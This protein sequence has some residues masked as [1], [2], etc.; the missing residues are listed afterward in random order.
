MTE[1]TAAYWALTFSKMTGWVVEL[2]LIWIMINKFQ[3]IGGWKPF[4]VML[5]YAL[6]LS[7]YSIA[8]FFLFHPFTKLSERI[9]KGELDDILTKPVNPFLYLC[10]R[11]FSAGY[12]SNLFT[13]LVALVI[14]F[15]QLGIDMNP[16][17]ILFL[18][19][20][21]LGGALIQGAALIF[22]GVPSFW[23]VQNT[24]LS[25]IILWDSLSFVRYPLSAYSTGI[26]ILLTLVIPYA[27]IS[28]YPA[29][30][31]LA[32]QDFLIFHPVFQFLSP[33]VGALLFFIAYQVWKIGLTNYQSSGS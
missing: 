23:L 19:Y 1:N 5:L 8:G 18:I 22:S 33:L 13:G 10:S 28:F 30:F 21:L 32:K 11:E 25:R 3:T 14:C 29:Q 7:S 26:Q 24:A 2:V 20:T 31:F 6:N 15:I 17:K 4:E 16:V 27:F 12:F 9:R